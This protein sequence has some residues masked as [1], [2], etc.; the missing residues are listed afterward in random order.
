MEIKISA[1]H[2]DIERLKKLLKE[3]GVGYESDSSINQWKKFEGVA[4]STTSKPYETRHLVTNADWVTIALL[5]INSVS[6]L[7]KLLDI[8]LNNVNK[9]SKSP[10]VHIEGEVVVINQS[11]PEESIEKIKN[12]DVEEAEK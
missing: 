10:K 6:V 3:E 8:W 11:V 9:E 4:D 12:I 2:E 5:G 7:A 1:Q